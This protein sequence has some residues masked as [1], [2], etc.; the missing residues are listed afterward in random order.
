M[1][2]LG[3]IAAVLLAISGTVAGMGWIAKRLVNSII[4]Q[5]KQFVDESIASMKLNAAALGS[6]HLMMNH[7]QDLHDE[8]DKTLFR[9]LDRIE[10]KL[11]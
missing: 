3:A 4:A 5:N 11:P 10:G 6:M 7:H 1:E 8:R 2:I 9:Q